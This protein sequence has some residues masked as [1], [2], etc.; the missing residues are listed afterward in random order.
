MFLLYA[1]DRDLIPSRTD[2][3]ARAFYAQ[4]YG[5]RSLYA[6]LLDDRAK[7]PDT[8][9]ERRG[10][11][12]RLLAL[13]SLVHHGDRTGWVRGRGGRLF[14]PAV[15]PFLQGQEQPGDAPAPAPVSDGSIL[16]ILDALITVDGE[17]LSYRTLDVEQI[18]SV[19]E[20]VIGFAVETRAGPAVAI[21]AGKNDRT[22]VFVDLAALAAVKGAERQK[23]LKEEAG[24]NALP[25]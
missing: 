14:D 24:R 10:A 8:M 19:Y 22:P 18:G 6:Q 7:H 4:G 21:K 20:T 9:D 25:R 13:F 16:R 3:E 12:G 11:W 23:F 1:E 2:A 15:Y 5:V 17:K